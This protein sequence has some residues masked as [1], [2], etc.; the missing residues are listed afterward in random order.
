MIKWNWYWNR[1]WNQTLYLLNEVISHAQSFLA[2]I[3]SVLWKKRTQTYMYERILFDW[4]CFLHT[5]VC[6]LHT[7][8]TYNT[9][10]HDLSL[11]LP[12]PV[13]CGNYHS[14][15]NLLQI[16]LNWFRLVILNRSFATLVIVVFFFCLST[17]IFQIERSHEIVWL[18]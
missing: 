13:R 14:N 5:F 4:I 11:F 3:F 16:K 9:Y 2:C 12:Q 15:Y 6:L 10:E 7:T 17:I 1:T 18:S 8:T